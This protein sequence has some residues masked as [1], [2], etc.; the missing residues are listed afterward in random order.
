MKASFAMEFMLDH[1]LF[2]T[3]AIFSQKVR[4]GLL[5]LY[6]QIEYLKKSLAL[7]EVLHGSFSEASSSMSLAS[8]LALDNLI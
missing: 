8:T 3:C 4:E 2:L 1:I 7:L 5:T 6:Y